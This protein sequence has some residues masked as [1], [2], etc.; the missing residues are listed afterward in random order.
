MES[1]PDL[2]HLF[3][4]ALALVAMSLDR[5]FPVP[6]AVSYCGTLRT[7][8][9]RHGRHRLVSPRHDVSDILWLSQRARR[10]MHPLNRGGMAQMLVPQ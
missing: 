7:L 2:L 10:P 1:A 3:V 4:K 5:W 9:R 8:R 6:W